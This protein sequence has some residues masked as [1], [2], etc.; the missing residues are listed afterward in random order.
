MWPYQLRISALKTAHSPS[1]SDVCVSSW[2]DKL[3]VRA[4]F[5]FSGSV[6]WWEFTCIANL[7]LELFKLLPSRTSLSFSKL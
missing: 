3:A 1:T 2:Q 5:C 6:F 4:A 7:Q